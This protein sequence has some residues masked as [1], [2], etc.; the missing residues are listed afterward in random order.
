MRLVETQ[1]L[2]AMRE[3]LTGHDDAAT[4]RA[5]GKLD[6]YEDVLT[7]LDRVLPPVEAYYD[8]QLERKQLAVAKPDTARH[9]GSSFFD[10]S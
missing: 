7:I 1:A 10:W 3:V 6:A 4:Q 5:R 8:R 9:W 2:T